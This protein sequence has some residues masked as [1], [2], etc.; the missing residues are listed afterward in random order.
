MGNWACSQTFLE[1]Y[2]YIHL[3]EKAY[4]FRKFLAIFVRKKF[5]SKSPLSLNHPCL[6]TSN[7]A[8]GKSWDVFKNECLL[9]NTLAVSYVKIQ[10]G[11]GM[12]SFCRHPCVLCM[13]YNIFKFSVILMFLIWQRIISI[14]I[15]NKSDN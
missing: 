10:G 7:N 2:I 1:K 8:D 15:I 4:H 5:V 6:L 3:R 9:K 11:G 12:T 14:N 13:V